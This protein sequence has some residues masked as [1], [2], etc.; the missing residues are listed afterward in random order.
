MR[1]LLAA[2]LFATACGSAYADQVAA[3]DHNPGPQIAIDVA[4]AKIRAPY[5]VQIIRE[6]GETLADL[7]GAR[8]VLRRG[9][10]PASATRFEISNPT[11]HR[12]EAVVSVDGLDAV[13]GESR[14]SPQARLH[15]ARRTATVNIEGF[16]TSLADVAT[17]RFSS[18]DG[19]YA[20]QKGK[21]RNVGVIAVAL[22]EE[23]HAPDVQIVTPNSGYN[24]TD[25]LDERSIE[26]G[27]RRDAREDARRDRAA[28]K[29]SRTPTSRLRA[30]THEEASAPPAATRRADART[31]VG[32]AYAAAVRR[33]R[34]EERIDADD[35][36]RRADDDGDGTNRATRAPPTNR[37]GL[38]TEFGEAR[39][40]AASYT[41]FM[42]STTRP[43]A[44][45]ELRYND[46]AGLMALG[47]PVQPMPDE[48]EIMTRET[49]DPF[50]GDHFARPAR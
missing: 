23:E 15:R 22:F 26:L 42:R 5:D 29:P 7:R 20:G 25:D 30:A 37:P 49:A 12:V 18:V 17:F 34:Y 32:G 4:P 28:Q 39:Y 31:A 2:L 45:A 10:S 48:N 47:I 21:A 1:N 19:S 38:G 9:H 35:E 14:R 43:I 36:Q 44:I 11:G 3:S 27:T 50:P 8:S 41:Q 6:D 13:D 24:Y 46:A 40:S 33:R 16:R